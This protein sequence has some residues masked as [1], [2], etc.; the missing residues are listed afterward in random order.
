[1]FIGKL[2]LIDFLIISDSLGHKNTVYSIN[3]LIE[4]TVFLWTKT[5][6]WLLILVRNG[7]P[8]NDHDTGS[9]GM[10]LISDLIGCLNGLKSLH[11]LTL[12][13]HVH[14]DLIP[15]IQNE[16][17]TFVHRSYFQW[18]LFHSDILDTFYLK[19]IYQ[20]NRFSKHLN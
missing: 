17:V 9:A 10:I 8:T 12:G 1:M 5:S 18:Y 20:W 19:P 2:I 3:I 15:S 13:S 6:D 11:P 4:Y 7:E 14:Q 16:A